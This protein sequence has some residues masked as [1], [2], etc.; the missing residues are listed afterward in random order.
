M[1]TKRLTAII[2]ALVMTMSFTACRHSLGSDLSLSSD[3]SILSSEASVESDVND[4]SSNSSTDGTSESKTSTKG[5]TATQKPVGG[6]TIKEVPSV[7]Q[8]TTP[9]EQGLD[10]GGRTLKLA[11]GYTVTTSFVNMVAAF[12]KAYNCKVEITNLSY[13]KY[14]ADLSAK[15]TSG[16]TYD[17]I[18]MHGSFYPNAI[19]KG[20][21]QP[22][23]D[24]YTAADF[25]DP[26]NLSAGGIDSVKSNGF[27]WNGHIYCVTGYK[28]SVPML[29]YN[30]RMM[31]AAG[32]SGNND[33]M[34]LYNS[35]GWSYNKLKE[36]GKVVTDSQKGVYLGGKDFFGGGL[37]A[38]N[39]GQF[40]KMNGNKVTENLTDSRIYNAYAFQRDIS[41]G[42]NAIISFTTG[43][44]GQDYSAFSNGKT[45]MFYNDS[46]IYAKLA[47]MAAE[48]SNFSKNKDNLGYVPFPFGPD[49][50]NKEYFIKWLEGW[51]A[52]LGCSDKRAAIAFAKFQ[53]KWQDNGNSKYSA[54]KDF[55]NLVDKLLTGKVFWNLGGFA[56]KSTYIP[57]LQDELSYD[58]TDSN[59]DL[60]AILS[61]YRNKVQSCLNE[62]FS[63]N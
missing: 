52:G 32:Y 7:A 42:S 2:L 44:G 17:I 50:T 55:N 35:G 15:I 27:A 25:Y 45:Y 58:L 37:V 21:Y 20:F 56:G 39:R 23:E 16:E 1:K 11:I 34:A 8:G 62:C 14:L 28:T 54:P 30:K 60:S 47:K 18:Y 59:N 41:V 57:G 6:A 5:S 24:K 49:N 9:V 40:I 63:G 53:S 43:T 13:D 46:A 48:S 51:G 38:F 19:I 4:L 61:S 36:I 31:A 12:E 33:P 26:S 29:Y 3:G 22:L 10:F